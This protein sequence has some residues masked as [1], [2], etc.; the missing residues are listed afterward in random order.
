MVGDTPFD[1][2]MG[3]GAGVATCAVATGGF[4]AAELA[5]RRPAMLLRSF[6]DLPGLLPLG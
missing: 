6:A 1:L 5:C 4:T 2:E 3:H